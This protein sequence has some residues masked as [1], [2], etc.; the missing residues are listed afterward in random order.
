MNILLACANGLSTSMLAEKM[1]LAAEKIK[2]DCRIWAV[3]VESIETEL[4]NNEI[5]CILLGPQ[6]KFMSDDIIEL[7]YQHGIPVCVINSLDYGQMNAD[8]VLKNALSTLHE[9]VK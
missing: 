6:V 2:I 7:G 5:S 1:Q 9:G 4:E 3:D 8:K